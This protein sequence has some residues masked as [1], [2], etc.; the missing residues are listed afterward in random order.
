[1]TPGTQG[2]VK[3]NAGPVQFGRKAIRERIRL[4]AGHLPKTSVPAT[5]HDVG[6]NY[7]KTT[8]NKNAVKQT[9]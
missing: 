3:R 7:K 8:P 5:R 1:M 9:G 4:Q 6:K 2:I